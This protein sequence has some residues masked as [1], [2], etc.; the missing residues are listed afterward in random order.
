[1]KSSL[2][3]LSFLNQIDLSDSLFFSLI[4]SALFFRREIQT[5]RVEYLG[6]FHLVIFR[7]STSF[8][9]SDFCIFL[10]EGKLKFTYFYSLS[11]G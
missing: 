1:M 8:N 2:L 11:G 3:W 4:N 6:V 7:S 10:S 9:L 5:I